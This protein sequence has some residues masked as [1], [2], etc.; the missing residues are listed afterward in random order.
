MAVSKTSPPMPCATPSPPGSTGSARTGSRRAWPRRPRCR[1]PAGS[2]SARSSRTRRAGRSRSSTTIQT[3]D[4]VDLGAPAR[5][6]RA[7]GPAGRPLPGPGPGQRRRGPGQGRLRG[8]WTSTTRSATLLGLPHLAVRGLM[9]VGRLT[10]D[11]D[12]AR[13]T[14]RGLRD[15]VRAVPRPLA[16]AR[17][18]AVDGDDRRL[19]AGGRGGRDHRPGRPGAVRR[20]PTPRRR[21][22]PAGREA[23]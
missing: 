16:G 5:S 11:P 10:T 14:F 4:S 15:A 20:A 9:T 7:G 13:R 23:P 1:A 6:A 8:G 18:G 12:E 17:P 22:A 2:S 21:S 3:V 19:R